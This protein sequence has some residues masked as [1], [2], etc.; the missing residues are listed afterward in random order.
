LWVGY[1]ADIS[2]KLLSPSSGFNH[3]E[4][5]KSIKLLCLNRYALTIIP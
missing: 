3:N 4:S 1:D 5:L 2:E